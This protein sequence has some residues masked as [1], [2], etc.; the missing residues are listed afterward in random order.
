MS[1]L[2]SIVRIALGASILAGAAISDLRTRTASNGFWLVAGTAGLGILAYE[3]LADI[4]GWGALITQT[5]DYGH[6]L[7]LITIGLRM[8]LLF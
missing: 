4:L 6:L 2:L 3:M 8:V 7:I 1:E 5:Y